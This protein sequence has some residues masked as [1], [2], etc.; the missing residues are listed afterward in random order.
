MDLNI[1]RNE[2]SSL[3]EHVFYVKKGA[4]HFQNN[5]SA[6]KTVTS[7]LPAPR[8]IAWNFQRLR[9]RREHTRWFFRA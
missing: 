7:H 9:Q 2:L 8:S 4:L 5:L 1:V 3:L 6:S